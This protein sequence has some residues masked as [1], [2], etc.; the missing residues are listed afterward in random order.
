MSA[1]THETILTTSETVTELKALGVKP[2]KLS[3]F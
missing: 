3:K 1:R 2:F